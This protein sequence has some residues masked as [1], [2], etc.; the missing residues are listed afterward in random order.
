MCACGGRNQPWNQTSRPEW[1]FTPADGG[2]K[3]LYWS[4]QEAQRAQAAFGGSY[5]YVGIGR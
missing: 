1:E 4:E 5:K 2:A 3:Q